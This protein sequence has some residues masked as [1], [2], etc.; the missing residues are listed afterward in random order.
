M[1]NGD[2]KAGMVDDIWQVI[3]SEWV[4]LAFARWKPQEP[5]PEQDS[6]GVD[7]ARG[8]DDKTVIAQRYG[9]WYAPLIRYEGKQTPDG[10]TTATYTLMAQRDKAPIHI[11]VIG[12][13]S[14]PFDILRDREVQVIGVNVANKSN[15]SD[16]TGH[17]RFLNLR[18][19]LWWRLREALDPANNQAIALHPDSRLKADLTA[20]KWKLQGS[21]IVVESREDV[22][23]RIGRS[24]DDASAVILAQIETPKLHLVRGA[25]KGAGLGDYDPYAALKPR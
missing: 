10:H 2:F 7:V 6:L 17:L 13:G 1:L 3:P 11:D 25:H 12:V 19:E 8:G 4:D 16:R 21:V 23:K 20:P 14:S 9:R 24:P 15:G 5:L 22:H 18:S